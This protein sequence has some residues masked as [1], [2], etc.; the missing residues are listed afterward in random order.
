MASG[1]TGKRFTQ[2]PSPVPG[3]THDVL[4]SREVP[5][6]NSEFTVLQACPLGTIRW[7]L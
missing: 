1:L 4:Y 3:V 2:G 7:F 5:Q 6:V